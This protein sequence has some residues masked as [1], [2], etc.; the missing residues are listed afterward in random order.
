MHR[1]AG[2][3]LEESVVLDRGS[4]REIANPVR[5]GAVAAHILCGPALIMSRRQRQGDPRKRQ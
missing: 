3:F 5:E 4:A 1:S 2:G